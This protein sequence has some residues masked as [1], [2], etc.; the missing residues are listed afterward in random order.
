MCCLA[1]AGCK[2]PPCQQSLLEGSAGCKVTPSHR[3]RLEQQVMGM[4]LSMICE[5]WS[6]PG[7]SLQE[8]VLQG[9]KSR[10]APVVPEFFS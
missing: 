5:G 6:T 2:A 9:C 10:G 8:T 3:D 4:L 7:T 1:R